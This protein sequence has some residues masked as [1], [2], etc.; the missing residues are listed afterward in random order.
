MRRFIKLDLQIY[1][2]AMKK[3]FLFIL[4]LII[5]VLA[6]WTYLIVKSRYFP[7]AKEAPSSQVP[8][9]NQQEE[10]Q[11]ATKEETQQPSLPEEEKIKFE[12][13]KTPENSLVKITAADCDNECKNFKDDENN[14]KYCQE[15]C[16]LV[17]S[18][19][20][21]EN[22]ENLKNLEKDYCLKDLA[23]SKKDF[24][25]CDQIQD[26]GVKKTCKNRVSEDILEES[27]L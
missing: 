25:I 10:E 27:G 18:E 23:V 24:N 19:E 21:T 8:S 4:I 6:W 15:I 5:I 2:F 13:S 12:E 22:C 1:Y 7:P 20:I 11:A 17:V 3:F 16:G 9:E 26:S 14:L